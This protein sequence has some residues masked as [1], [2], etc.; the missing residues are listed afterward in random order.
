MIKWTKKDCMKAIIEL[1]SPLGDKQ[2]GQ[3]NNLT[4]AIEDLRTI[5]PTTAPFKM[6]SKPRL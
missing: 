1:R 5:K 6:P 2:S 3:S 4:P